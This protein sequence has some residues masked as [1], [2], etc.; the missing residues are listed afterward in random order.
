MKQ[1][2]WLLPV[3]IVCHT[4]VGQT[5]Q[6]VS[7]ELFQSRGAANSA[8][9]SAQTAWQFQNPAAMK[10]L[11]HY[12]VKD[13]R[14]LIDSAWGSGISAAEKLNFFD[15]YWTLFDQTWGGFPN[16]T[17]N[18]DS[19]K[20][21]YRSQV[22]AGV[23]RGRFYGILT[24]MSRA[25]NEW[26]S[27]A[28]DTGIDSTFKYYT[29]TEYPF[30]SYVYKPGIPIFSVNPCFFQTCFG[31]GVTALPDSTALVYSV[32]PNHPLGLHPGDIV[33]GYDGIPWKDLVKEILDAELPISYG[34]CLLGSTPYVAFHVSTMSVGMNWGLF[35]TIDI[36][37]YWT[38][39]TV[40][41]PTSLLKSITPPYFVATEQLPVKGVPFPNFAAKKFV[42]SGIVEGTKIGYIY[43]WDWMGVPA[44][45]NQTRILFGQAMTDLLQ[46][47]GLSGLVLDFRTNAGGLTEYANDGFKQIFNFD[48]TKN[49]SQAKRISGGAHNEFTI[50]TPRAA[51]NFTPGTFI[52]DRPIAV[53]VGP[54]CGSSGDYNAFRMRFHPMARFF[55]KRTN[56]AYTAYFTGDKRWAGSYYYRV[57]NGSIFTT[58]NNEGYLIHKSFPVDKDV[59]L[60]Q[61]GAVCG[62]DDVVKQAVEWINAVAYASSPVTDKMNYRQ[63]DTIVLSVTVRNPLNHNLAL[64]GKLFTTSDVVAD[65]AQF[66]NDGLHGDGAAND[67]IWACILKTPPVNWNLSFY[68]SI[69]FTDK[70]IGTSREISYRNS[71]ATPVPVAAERFPKEFSLC[72]NYPNPFN[73]STTIEY[74]IPRQSC[75]M[76]KVFDL[77]GREVAVLVDEKK[78]AGK[79][80]VRWNASRC[81][82]GVYFCRLA[83]DN[84]VS[85]KK[86]I[87]LR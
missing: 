18:W 87:L 62:E 21:V 15:F 47:P 82:S 42:S 9:S 44:S 17:V 38:K 25:L 36:F 39:D 43:A 56:G 22:A 4:L 37:R 79:Y 29:V 65:S 51:E 41:L 12:T 77:L 78:P 53:L 66:F 73:P 75:I 80:S 60:T 68:F 52:F 40:H 64:T 7:G 63:R 34:A 20:S 26:H 30:T 59:W 50:T 54:N 6:Q 84:F 31:A 3:L 61:E 33:L 71:I 28:L 49:Y 27:Y 32:M 70:S 14:N 57:D 2:C 48:P 19:L 35:D 55:G 16:T 13:W 45:T 72:Q 58:Y 81:A 46:T 10:R 76:V 85:T 23:S 83:A 8:A 86:L 67:T 24:R 1:T 5:E 69:R 74:N 11:G